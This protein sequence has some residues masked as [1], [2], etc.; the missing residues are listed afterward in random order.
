MILTLELVLFV[1]IAAFVSSVIS[2]WA[3]GYALQTHKQ[4]IVELYTRVHHIDAALHYHGL[5]PLPWET[6][7]IENYFS[8]MK[9]LKR[10]GNVVYLNQEEE[11]TNE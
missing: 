11:Q 9:T 10:D 2:L 4:T 6:E 3:F 8:E 7:E 1:S 5:T